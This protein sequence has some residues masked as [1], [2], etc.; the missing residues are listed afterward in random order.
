MIHLEST[1]TKNDYKRA[2]QKNYQYQKQ[3]VNLISIVFVILMGILFYY[4]NLVQ[5]I[6]LLIII[7]FFVTVVLIGIIRSKNIYSKNKHYFEGKKEI[8]FDSFLEI[9]YQ[10]EHSIMINI[11]ELKQIKKIH[12]MN[13]LIVIYIECH[14]NTNIPLVINEKVFKK[15]NIE[16][17]LI[18]L[19]EHKIKFTYLT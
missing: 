18:Y 8:K 6:I 4:A 14:M 9:S 12:F 16:A 17:F 13:D 15:G 2:Y 5:R 10:K 3:E 19:M 11:I 1:A 7:A